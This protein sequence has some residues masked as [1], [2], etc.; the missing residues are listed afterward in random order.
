MVW[1]IILD[2]GLGILLVRLYCIDRDTSDK[3]DLERVCQHERQFG[4]FSDKWS[5]SDK[6]RWISMYGVSSGD[7]V[8]TIG[9]VVAV[10]LF[11]LLMTFL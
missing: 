5:Y 4:R 7:P 11:S 9:M 1:T 3:S 8:R 6:L 10:A 2:A